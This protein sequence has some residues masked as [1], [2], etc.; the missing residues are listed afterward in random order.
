[1]ST[2][3]LAPVKSISSLDSYTGLRL[4]DDELG[5]TQSSPLLLDETS[6]RQ[7]SAQQQ[8]TTP[9]NTSKHLSPLLDQVLRA[10]GQY[11]SPNTTSPGATG[12]LK[13]LGE[14][15]KEE[16]PLSSSFTELLE[17][18]DLERDN[19]W[20]DTQV[21]IV[22]HIYIATATTHMGSSA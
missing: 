15:K 19:A 17:S 8:P 20:M 1:M 14:D 10:K 13:E 2:V 11:S 3:F 16:R 21:K 7:I 5:P 4:P 18:R 22:M 9:T 12:G 6:P